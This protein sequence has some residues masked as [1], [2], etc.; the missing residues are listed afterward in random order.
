MLLHQHGFKVISGLHATMLII[1]EGGGA[2][3]ITSLTATSVML[4]RRKKRDRILRSFR[5]LTVF[6]LQ[7]IPNTIVELNATLLKIIDGGVLLHQRGLNIIL[8][9]APTMLVIIESGGDR[10]ITSL[11]T[12]SFMLTRRTKCDRTLLHDMIRGL[13][14]AGMKREDGNSISQVLHI[15][16]RFLAVNVKHGIKECEIAFH[17][18]VQFARIAVIGVRIAPVYLGRNTRFVGLATT[19]ICIC[20]SIADGENISSAKGAGRHI[21]SSKHSFGK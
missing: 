4:T 5:V 10:P 14:A 6:L 11:T 1:I 15:K 12:M 17:V 18:G 3:P 8:G 9:M 19:Q 21:M 16:L 7:P 2:R 20:G 13:N